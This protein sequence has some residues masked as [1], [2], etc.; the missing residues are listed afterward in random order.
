M[1]N[2]E[3]G[4]G[5]FYAFIRHG[6]R[7]DQADEGFIFHRVEENSLD[8]PLTFKGIEQ[9]KATGKLLKDMLS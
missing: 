2:H 7:S 3:N 6:Q 1:D 5:H 9:A 8:P 4:K